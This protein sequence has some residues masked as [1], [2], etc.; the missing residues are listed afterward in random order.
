MLGGC[1]DLSR[2]TPIIYS[3][4]ITG[5]AR[6]FFPETVLKQG[7][8]LL[9]N[10]KECRREKKVCPFFLLENS[11][12]LSPWGPLDFL[13]TCLGNDSLSSKIM[14]KIL[15]VKL[16]QYVNQELPDIQV[17]LR[18]QRN[19]ISNCQ[20]LLDHRKS[21]RIPEKHLFLLH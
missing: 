9:Y 2:P 18:R 16:Q 12:L 6:R 13:S 15:Q 14:L 3:F 20:H 8:L 17:E 10:P 21:K 19:Q 5:L 4:K 7:T 11:R 1:T